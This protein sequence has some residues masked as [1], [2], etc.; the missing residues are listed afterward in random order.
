MNRV[1]DVP[2][3]TTS[4]A[5]S[6]PRMGLRGPRKPKTR[7]PIRPDPLGMTRLRARQSP[8]WLVAHRELNTSRRVRVVYD[9]MADEL[10]RPPDLAAD[11][12]D[13]TSVASSVREVYQDVIAGRTR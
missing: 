6:V 5:I 8:I 9:I 7:R 4:P 10:A 11:R 1:T 12:F 3:A 13:V 2:M